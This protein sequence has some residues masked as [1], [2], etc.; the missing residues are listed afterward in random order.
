M[1]LKAS[2]YVFKGLSESKTALKFSKIHLLKYLLLTIASILGKFF[3]FSY[4]IF[5]FSEYHI[6]NQIREKVLFDL[7]D[8]FVDS[9]SI[10]KYWT[11]AVGAL[12]YHFI[13]LSGTLFIGLI[14]YFLT[15]IGSG[16]NGFSRIFGLSWVS[17]FLT[18]C[19]AVLVV[20]L[21]WC[22]IIFEPIVFYIQ[23]NEDIGFS[24]AY[25]QVK[26]WMSKVGRWKLFVIRLFHWGIFIV[27]GIIGTVFAI[28]MYR[29]W[30]FFWFIIIATPLGFFII[31]KLPRLILSNRIASSKLFYDLMNES[32]YLSL[33]DQEHTTAFHSSKIRKESVLVALF[34][35]VIVEDSPKPSKTSLE[36]GL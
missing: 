25:H 28:Y 24:E 27:Y 6:V 12:I 22:S 33:F 19:I 4:P 8:V 3:F 11:M 35:E 10:K 23:S 2:N 16:L 26:A 13:L 14:T 18:I 20:F 36:E 17:F 31:L 5:A 9:K 29:N 15:F 30:A 1:I 34:D 21:A 32:V 7:E